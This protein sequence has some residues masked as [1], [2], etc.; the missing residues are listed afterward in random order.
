[1]EDG[2]NRRFSHAH[3]ARYS[4]QPLRYATHHEINTIG[5]VANS[6]HHIGRTKSAI[7]PSAMNSVQK[8]LRSISSIVAGMHSAFSVCLARREA[9]VIG[10]HGAYIVA[11]ILRLPIFP[12][13][14]ACASGIRLC[15]S[16]V[17]SPPSVALPLI[18]ICDVTQPG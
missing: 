8:T 9:I 2:A 16:I 10:P 13:M 4:S 11:A 1:M 7:K 12:V 6:A 17:K 5:M 15:H 18:L 3:A 14:V